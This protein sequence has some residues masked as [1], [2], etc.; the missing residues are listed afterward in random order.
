MTELSATIDQKQMHGSDKVQD[1]GGLYMFTTPERRIKP[2]VICDY[3]AIVEG[4]DTQGNKF[5]DD[6]KLANLSAGGLYMWSNHNV[7]Q[8]AKLSVIINLPSVLIDEETPKLATKGIVVRTEPKP[9]GTV[10]V[11]LRFYNY[12]FM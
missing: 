3:P 9:N 10:G 12:R 5:R 6:A 7:E 8:G 2:R 4:I 11:A 1:K